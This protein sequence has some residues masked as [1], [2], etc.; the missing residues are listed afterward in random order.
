VPEV[1][2]GSSCDAAVVELEQSAETFMAPVYLQEE[3][4]PSTIAI[5]HAQTASN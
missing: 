2:R 5:V 4:P 1:D 3:N